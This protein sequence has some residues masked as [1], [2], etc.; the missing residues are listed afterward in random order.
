M[1]MIAEGQLTVLQ[2]IVTDRLLLT[3]LQGLVVVGFL[4]T[5]LLAAHLLVRAVRTDTGE[6]RTRD[7]KLMLAGA[8]VMFVLGFTRLTATDGIPAEPLAS[9]ALGFAGVAYL[10]YTTRPELFERAEDDRTPASVEE[11]TD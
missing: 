7:A 11:P 3:V 6:F 10:L 4:G 2:T 1:Y 5:S 8:S 9:V